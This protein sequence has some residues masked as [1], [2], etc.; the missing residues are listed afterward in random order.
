MRT[1]REVAELLVERYMRDA[2]WSIG[3]ITAT[4][5]N[6][7]A[8]R[9]EE[10]KRRTE[11]RLTEGYLEA[12]ASAAGVPAGSELTPLAI[13]LL[14]KLGKLCDELGANTLE[15]AHHSL[16]EMRHVLGF[17]ADEK[18][19]YKARLGASQLNVMKFDEDNIGGGNVQGDRARQVLKKYKRVEDIHG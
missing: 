12:R 18:N 9:E 17:Y 16:N 2:A 6:W 4:L 8:S 14:E 10:I 1:A 19:W 7:M 13:E 15:Q 3:G 11:S 5:N